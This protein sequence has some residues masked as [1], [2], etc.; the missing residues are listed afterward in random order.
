MQPGCSPNQAATQVH[1]PRTHPH[2]SRPPPPKPRR[3]RQLA[4]ALLLRDLLPG[5]SSPPQLFD[6][7]FSATDAALIAALGCQVIATNEG[8]ARVA[9]E[10]TLFYLPHCEVSRHRAL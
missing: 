2:S 9:E 7:A 10:Q 5:L 4:L 6:P 1:W 3:A 8:G